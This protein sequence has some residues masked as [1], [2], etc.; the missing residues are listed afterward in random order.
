VAQLQQ[1]PFHPKWR[2][3]AI[4]ASVTGWTRARP[5]QEWLDRHAPPA[6]TLAVKQSGAPEENRAQFNQFLD[7]RAARGP[8]ATSRPEGHDAIFNE[9]LQWQASRSV[10]R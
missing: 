2:E 1:P 7:E 10:R 8:T 5:A 3:L 6:A 4:G 9:F